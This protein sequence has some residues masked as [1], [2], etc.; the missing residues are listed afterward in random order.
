MDSFGAFPFAGDL[1]IGQIAD[2]YGLSVPEAEKATPVG[3]FVAARLLARPAVGDG[4]G[5]GL[6]G[7]VVYDLNGQRIT[8]VGAQ[9]L[10]SWHAGLCLSKLA[11]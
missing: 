8:H 3:G 7:L 11:A 5:I 4:I 2:F 10:I 1:P 6:V 9:G